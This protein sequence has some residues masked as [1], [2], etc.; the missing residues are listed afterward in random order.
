MLTWLCDRS[1]TIF[2]SLSKELPNSSCRYKRTYD[3]DLRANTGYF[4]M[5]EMQSPC[6]FMDALD[7]LRTKA[8]HAAP[9]TCRGQMETMSNDM[10]CLHA[11]ERSHG[12][13]GL[14]FVRH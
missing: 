13:P 10:W 6:F 3:F 14:L 9:T 2:S 12:R 4:E 7:V 11:R 8:D 5:K 1:K